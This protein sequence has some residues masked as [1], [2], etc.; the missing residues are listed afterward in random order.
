MNLSVPDG[1]ALLS[2]A[3]VSSELCEGRAL[4]YEGKEAKVRKTAPAL[5]RGAR[6]LLCGCSAGR[7]WLLAGWQ[8][9]AGC[10]PRGSA[11]GQVRAAAKCWH[12]G[13][14]PGD[15]PGPWE[16][17]QNCW[18]TASGRLPSGVRF[19]ACQRK[20]KG[21]GPGGKHFLEGG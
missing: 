17:P 5:G 9:P 20:R 19:L 16:L 12:A 6:G 14:G 1:E 3:T 11:R 4:V 8:R 18:Q 2:S 15:P 13:E 10:R 7:V 21:K